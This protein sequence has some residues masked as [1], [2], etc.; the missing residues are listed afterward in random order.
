MRYDIPSNAMR[1]SATFILL[2]AASVGVLAQTKPQKAATP[3]K[4]PAQAAAPAAKAEAHAHYECPMHPS[5]RSKTPGKCP[6]CGMVLRKTEQAAAPGPAPVA[7]MGLR[8]DGRP[9]TIPDLE[10]VDQDGRKIRFYTDLVKDKT[11]AINFVFTT[12]TTIC[13]PLG[14]TFAR[15]QKELG[16]RVGKDVHFISIS[17]DPVTDTPERLKAWG[18]KFHAGPGWTFVTGDKTSI[19]QLLNALAASASKREDH[20]PTIV[21][22]NDAKNIVTRTYGLARPSQ[23]IKVIDDTITGGPA[24]ASAPKE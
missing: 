17:V 20:S 2:L 5:V 4:S 15:I 16:P 24:V 12:C 14:A 9:S 1:L 3:A 6:K 22:I 13:P 18:A 23:I 11:V 7:A 21:V 10:L 19:D 8:A